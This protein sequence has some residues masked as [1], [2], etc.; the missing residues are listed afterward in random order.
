M[1]FVGNFMKF[2]FAN[3]NYLRKV[4]II[5]EKPPKNENFHPF[6]AFSTMLRHETLEGNLKFGFSAPKNIYMQKIR[7]TPKLS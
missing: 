5:S 4:D 2:H 6:F 7:T 3:K 1:K